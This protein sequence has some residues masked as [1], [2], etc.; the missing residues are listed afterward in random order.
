M[1]HTV[2]TD[3]DVTQEPRALAWGRRESDGQYDWVDPDWADYVRR[4]EEAVQGRWVK[5]LYAIGGFA[6][7]TLDGQWHDC[8]S[9][10]AK[11]SFR[12]ISAETGAV[13]CRAC[14]PG[15]H[16]E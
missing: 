13:E 6:P 2:A 3:D 1:S 14:F 5:I 12:L 10:G 11:D 4:V 15:G 16:Q 8:P 7:Y 9:C